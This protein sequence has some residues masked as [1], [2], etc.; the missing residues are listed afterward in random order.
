[1]PKEIQYFFFGQDRGPFLFVIIVSILLS[2]RLTMHT[3]SITKLTLLDDGAAFTG[4]VI[5]WWIQEYVLHLHSKIDW[6]DKSIHE[7]HHSTSQSIPRHYYS[8]G[9]ALFL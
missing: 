2:T 9:W 7:A 4:D 1:M 6:I 5:F 3:L 8:G